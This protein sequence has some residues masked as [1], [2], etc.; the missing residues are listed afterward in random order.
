MK[1]FREV[2][3][4]CQLG[5]MDFQGTEFTWDNHR[6]GAAYVQV[7]LDRVMATT[8]WH[9]WF[10]ASSVVHLP[11]SRSNHVPILVKVLEIHRPP[12][13]RQRMHRFE[14]KWTTHPEYEDVI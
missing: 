2:L 8:Q 5:D 9:N 14:D 12:W 13:K 10:P 6:D 11:C 3:E 4:R 7:R 1:A